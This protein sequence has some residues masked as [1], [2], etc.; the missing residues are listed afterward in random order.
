MSAL[1]STFHMIR[2]RAVASLTDD[3]EFTT[4]ETAWLLL[5][6]AGWLALIIITGVSQ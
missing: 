4:T 3:A 2:S 1:V 5:P 6:F